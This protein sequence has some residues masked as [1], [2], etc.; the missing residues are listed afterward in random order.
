M[1]VQGKTLQRTGTVPRTEPEVTGFRL[2]P[3]MRGIVIRQI[4]LQIFLIGI[5]I[6][7]MFPVLWIVSMA[8]DPRGITRPT[9]LTLI[10]P[11]ANLAAFQRALT[12]PFSNM[13]NVYF[14]DMMM[15]SL[16]IALG[17]SIF[18]VVLGSSAA[19]AFSRFRF[20]GRQFGM[21]VFII[22]LMLPTTGVLIPLYVLFGS[23]TISSEVAQLP[24]ALFAGALIGA[25]IWVVFSLVRSFGKRNPERAFNPSP[26]LLVGLTA[27]LALVAIAGT[28]VVM[29]A[30]HPIYR[31]TIEDPL[32][33]ARVVVD[34]AKAEY[35]R[36]VTNLTRA[37]ERLAVR[38][39]N[40]EVAVDQL[41]ALVELQ[42]QFGTLDNAE[43]INALMLRE[44]EQRQAGE[45]PDDDLVLQ[46]L[47]IAQP[48]LETGGVEGFRAGLDTAVQTAQ[49]EVA[50]AQASA[51]ERRLD[52]E[53]TRAELEASEQALFDA[54]G[55]LSALTAPIDQIRNQTIISLIPYM[56]LA[57]A[58]ALIAAA[59]VWVIVRV[60]A[61]AVEPR[62]VINILALALI[63]SIIIG[64]GYMTLQYRLQTSGTG[65]TSLRSTLLGLSL[66]FASG[67]LPFAIWNLKGYFD[68][69]PKDL[70]EAALI[71][72][73]G[74]VG[75]FVRV[76]IPLAL[77]AF[78]I[79]ILFS[80]MSGWTEF[81]LS[82]LF[83]TGENESYTLAMNLASLAGGGNTAPPDMQ[84]FAALSILV[85]LPILLLFFAFQRWIVGG[86]AIGGVKG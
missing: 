37:E 27:V 25:I 46:S 52:V 57:W 34:D 33:D 60:L 3:R 75:T 66:A 36:A 70:E 19:Y 42:N 59:V 74:L 61:S 78:A 54:Q 32:L 41:A 14:G 35:D 39:Q 29:F 24:P 48:I 16:F 68:T 9:D 10:P 55:S 67:G 38:E 56:L 72:G 7:V 62:T 45:D 82:W 31:T 17:T 85:S 21:L 30:R 64:L 79:V 6:F 69:I 51:E 49:T 1:A 15:N 77:P 50:D 12:E 5:V 43:A 83:L 20:I 47:L 53:N 26:Q 71:D 65:T 81:I 44:I 8:V 22:L 73:A 40:A 76:M 11:N 2:T 23:I 13:V 18:T 4:F 84:K 28:F 63:A 80:F 58:G 86:L